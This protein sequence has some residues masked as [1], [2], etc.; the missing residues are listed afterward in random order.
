ML[1]VPRCAQQGARRWTS[2]RRCIEVGHSADQR[3]ARTATGADAVNLS[4]TIKSEDL[5][6]LQRPRRQKNFGKEEVRAHPAAAAR[7]RNSGSAHGPQPAKTPPRPHRSRRKWE[8]PVPEA[9]DPRRPPAQVGWLG[10]GAHSVPVDR[11]D[12]SWGV[13]SNSAFPR[14]LSAAFVAWNE[15]RLMMI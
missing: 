2:G 12:M 14:H 4:P 9:D 3:Q 11:A 8:F 1:R 13:R 6:H 7:S 15:N 10:E 5:R